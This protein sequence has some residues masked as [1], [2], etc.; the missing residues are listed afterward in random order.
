MPH[1]KTIQ[2][3]TYK[4][5]WFESETFPF[6]CKGN[7]TLINCKCNNKLFVMGSLVTMNSDFLFLDVAKKLYAKKCQVTELLSSCDDSYL[8]KV[9]A[10]GIIVIGNLKINNVITESLKIYSG[11]VSSKGTNKINNC[12][13]SIEVPIETQMDYDNRKS[14]KTYI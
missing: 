6:V 14:F 7:L 8:I 11:I 10:K 9:E 1:C 12:D 2:P 13:F 5:V 3:G 4:N